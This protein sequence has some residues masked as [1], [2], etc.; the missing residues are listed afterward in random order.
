MVWVRGKKCKGCW[1]GFPFK[2]QHAGQAPTHF[3]HGRTQR[4]QHFSM[5]SRFFSAS[6]ISWLIWSIPSS[7]RS[8]CSGT[9]KACREG[10]FWKPK[11]SKSTGHPLHRGTYAHIYTAVDLVGHQADLTHQLS[12]WRMPPWP[13]PRILDPRPSPPW[14]VCVCVCLRLTFSRAGHKAHSTF[15]FPA[16][17]SLH[18]SCPG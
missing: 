3:F 4:P 16:G 14:S 7:M 1:E 8:S 6:F 2:P 10:Q 12:T 18:L 13:P 5:P 15:P 9:D 17:F 11:K